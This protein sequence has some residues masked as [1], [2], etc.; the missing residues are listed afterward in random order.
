MVGSGLRKRGG[1]V[2]PGPVHF[3]DH[4]R[5]PRGA[6]LAVSTP[7]SSAFS[8]CRT[9]M[10][11][12]CGLSSVAMRPRA[13]ANFSGHKTDP[14]IIGGGRGNRT[15]VRVPEK[16]MTARDSWKRFSV[17]ACCSACTVAN[18]GCAPR[19]ALPDRKCSRRKSGRRSLLPAPER[20]RAMAE[21]TRRSLLQLRRIVAHNLRGQAVRSASSA[22]RA[23][24]SAPAS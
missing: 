8:A 3:P 22:S 10:S 13:P 19:A 7:L 24:P 21:R 11:L 14:K 2:R 18:R 23:A 16:S 15:R 4:R 1:E 9:K 20:S 17:A 6:R 5:A 12:S